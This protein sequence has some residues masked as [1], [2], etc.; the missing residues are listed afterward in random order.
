MERVEKLNNSFSNIGTVVFYKHHKYIP[1]SLDMLPEG[2]D[3]SASMV[4]YHGSTNNFPGIDFSE[5]D[6]SYLI[7]KYKF[8]NR[9]FISDLDT[10]SS[11]LV[12]RNIE[13]TDK[14]SKILF[15]TLVNEDTENPYD[16]FG[17]LTV[18]SRKLYF[19]EC[20]ENYQ[21]IEIYED[22]LDSNILGEEGGFI[23]YR[24]LKLLGRT[25][26]IKPSIII[27]LGPP[28]EAYNN[29]TEFYFPSDP[30]IDRE[31]RKSLEYTTIE[32]SRLCDEI[33]S[34]KVVCFFLS[35]N[36]NILDFNLSYSSWDGNV[37]PAR[38]KWKTE[39]RNDEY[40]D[41]LKNLNPIIKSDGSTWFDTR[42]E[43]I[44]GTDTIKNSLCPLMSGKL[45]RLKGTQK[46]YYSPY[47]TYSKG[48]ITTFRVLLPTGVYESY[49]VESLIQGNIGNDP[50]LSSAWILRDKILDFF[51]S[52]IYI[53]SNPISSG[54]IIDP[55]TQITVRGN[56]IVDFSISEGLGYFFTGLSII[57]R[58]G[59]TIDLVQSDDYTFTL[60]DTD[61]EYNKIVN[62]SS[63]G[64]YIDPESDR[65]TDHLVFN[66]EPSPTVIKITA[67]KDGIIYHYSDWASIFTPETFGVIFKLGDS[68]IQGDVNGD[69]L[70]LYID[71]P[72][73]NPTLK[74]EFTGS[75]VK[76]SIESRYRIG[77]RKYSKLIDIESS[78]EA[79]DIIDFN[80]AEYTINLESV[81]RYLSVR[82]VGRYIK[83][84]TPGFVTVDYGS[85]YTVTF[86]VL[87]D[88]GF[89]ISLV[90]FRYDE[91]D[92][93]VKY[94]NE[95]I[96]NS[97]PSQDHLELNN[98]ISVSASISQEDDG[99]YYLVLSGIK[100]NTMI[101]ITTN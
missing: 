7:E 60:Q 57:D 38:N 1:E 28:P 26:I 87:Q 59:E 32:Y 16:Y 19:F 12:G 94:D 58:T 31:N 100:E 56:S 86:K 69:D 46:N 101:Q 4:K 81:E 97:S 93:L 30:R 13:D 37:N 21:T 77:N 50:L 70:Y 76:P 78:Q 2:I 82:G 35:T 23:E 6:F 54:S 18:N 85:T 22:V 84:Y 98:Q 36:G 51:N 83:C 67:K 47:R 24:Y 20:P 10:E 39:L 88:F 5:Y 42:T 25:D 65:F 74:L 90:N 79:T 33:F 14:I 8:R 45:D 48:D 11:E 92:R 52:I 44:L 95:V 41:L 91:N 3:F 49:T 53:S 75:L 71:N 17:S 63:W 96:L 43:T 40:Y 15:P 55:G 27:N 99:K 34:S 89:I 80:E 9:L 68:I 73:L 72:Q 29:P 64:S 66:F 62:I 61:T